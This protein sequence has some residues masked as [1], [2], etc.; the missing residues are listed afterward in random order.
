MITLYIGNNLP[1]PIKGGS[2]TDIGTIVNINGD[3]IQIKSYDTGSVSFFDKY[4]I[5]KWLNNYLNQPENAEIKRSFGTINK[6]KHN[7][8]YITSHTKFSENGPEYRK[9]KTAKI[10]SKR[11]CRCKK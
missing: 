4:D 10:K 8:N 9:K 3:V 2:E 6:N 11:K 5:E 1:Y 7:I